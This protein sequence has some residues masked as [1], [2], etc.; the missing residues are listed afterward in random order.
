MEE[1]K[2]VSEV[3]ICITPLKNYQAIT[4]IIGNKKAAYA[5]FLQKRL[6]NSDSRLD[7]NTQATT[8][9]GSCGHVVV[10]VIHGIQP[11]LRVEWAAHAQR[12]RRNVH[13]LVC[14][15]FFF[16]FQGLFGFFLRFRNSSLFCPFCLAILCRTGYRKE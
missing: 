6:G 13:N 12:Q 5:A 11:I 4:P 9:S 15:H 16:R 10:A 2:A 3:F 1:G 14:R 7:S 8:V